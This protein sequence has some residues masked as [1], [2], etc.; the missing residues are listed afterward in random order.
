MNVLQGDQEKTP[1]RELAQLLR[2]WWEEAG[3]IPQKALARRL[4]DRGVKTS[5]EMISRYMSLD[6]PT[7]ARLDV[8]HA[9]HELLGRS[10]DELAR[11]LDLH[12]KATAPLP[13]PPLPPLPATPQSRRAAVWPVAVLVF[14][15]LATGGGVWWAT[16]ASGTGPNPEPDPPSPTATPIPTPTS[17][18]PQWPLAREGDRFW[19]ARTVQYLLVAHGHEVE[20]DG[21]FGPK[22]AAAVKE[23]QTRHALV[24]DGKVGPKTW[25]LLV[26]DV[27]SES[28]GAAVSAVQSLL[29]NAGLTTAV[30]GEF[31]AATARNLS[32]FQEV[33][34]LPVTGEADAST[35]RALM[36]A[37]LPPVHFPVS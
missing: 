36:D 26:L 8:I 33:H 1:K 37:Q 11:A 22:T 31:T 17:A 34:E 9:M 30:T 35:W 5:Q 4:T 32:T 18:A 3:R 6:R 23:F 14:T 2:S 28:K 13:P 25:P 7:V 12:A 16:S 27:R 20:V 15:I 21:I 19:K 24:A 10:P 29:T